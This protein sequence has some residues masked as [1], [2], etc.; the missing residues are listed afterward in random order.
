MMG[1]GDL[2]CSLYLSPKVLP[3]SPIY[4]SSTVYPSTAV[5]VDY[6]TLLQYGVLVLRMYQDISDSPTTLEVDFYTI[7]S[8]DVF[9]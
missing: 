8:A 7:S 6:S 3:D 9:A 4:S 2:M 1:D 5:L